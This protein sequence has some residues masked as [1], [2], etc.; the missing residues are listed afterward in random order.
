MKIKF[1]SVFVDD[2]DKALQFYTEV[3]GFIK[4]TDIPTGEFRWLTVVS[5]E[6]SDDIE[7]VLEPNVNPAARTYQE[8]IY[9]TGIP[10]TAFEVDDIRK[11]YERLKKLGVKFTT[12]PTKTEGP[13]VAV[14]DDSCG[15]LI[16]L[17]Q[18]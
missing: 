14:F 8:A 15:N 3:L 9:K 11:E 13:M 2:Q 4:K 16:Q 12:E 1:S 17:Y 18:E 5:H 10:S 6:G 7:L